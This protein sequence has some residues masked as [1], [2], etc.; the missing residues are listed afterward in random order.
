MPPLV[1]VRGYDEE[2]DGGSAG[3]I[4]FAED[5]WVSLGWGDCGLLDLIC[6]VYAVMVG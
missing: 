5:C 3:L 6:G 1:E 4:E 2:D